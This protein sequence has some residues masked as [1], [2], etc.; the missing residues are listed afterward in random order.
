[1]RKSQLAG[2]VTQCM[3]AASVFAQNQPPTPTTNSPTEIQRVVV[4]GSSLDD[5]ALRAAIE[6]AGYEASA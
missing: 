3:V 4:T 2:W 5:K 1:M 6:E